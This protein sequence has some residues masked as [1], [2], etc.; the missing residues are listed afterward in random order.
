[1]FEDRRVTAAD[2]FPDFEQP[3]RYDCNWNGSADRQPDF[4]GK[5]KRRRAE[6]NP[7]QRPENDRAPS[8]FRH[9]CFNSDI[10]MELGSFFSHGGIF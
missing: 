6:D 3:H 7:E 8:K 10:R 1:M 2:G 9:R 4:Q 5:I